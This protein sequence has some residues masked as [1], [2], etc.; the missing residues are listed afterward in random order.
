MTEHFDSA[1]EQWEDLFSGRAQNLRESEIRA[2]FS[3]VSRPEVISLAGG[4]PNLS[5]LPLQGIA[6]ATD[7]LISTHGEKAL[8]YG[9]GVGWD[10]LREQIVELMEHDSITA[11]KD[12]VVV[13]VGSQQALDLVSGLFLDPGDVVLAES[14]S[15]V[16]ALGVFRSHV[17]DVFQIE[18]DH[19]GLIP[20]ALERAIHENR[21]AGKTIKFLYTIPNYHNPAG[22]S[23]APWRRHEIVDICKENQVLIVEDN[24]YGLLG[25]HHDPAPALQSYWPEGVIYLGSFSKIFAPG[26]RV[27]WALMPQALVEKMTWASEAAILSPTMVG[28]MSISRYLRDFDWYAQV[29]T[30]RGL[31]HERWDVMDAALK[32]YLPECEWTVP[33]GGFYTWLTLPEGLDSKELLPAAVEGGVAY[34]PGTAFYYNGEGRDKLRLSFCYPP[35]DTIEEGIRRLSVVIK[36]AMPTA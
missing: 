20:E 16:G 29:Q 5:K 24:P 17:A 19:E 8:Q 1:G 21:K 27:G 22:V 10:P 15:Y 2:L 32:R 28:Q 14:P 6:E 13:T 30:F 9:D 33:R 7:T 36:N 12:D 11:D 3:V 25:F 4:M 18:M 34:V 31:Y 35:L 23:I 26:Y